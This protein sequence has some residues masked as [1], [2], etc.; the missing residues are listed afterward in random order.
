M[1][2]FLSRQSDGV[3]MAKI[4]RFVKEQNQ[5]KFFLY[6]THVEFFYVKLTLPIGEQKGCHR[7]TPASTAT[8]SAAA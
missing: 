2:A 3:Q 5:Q 4:Q 7:L 8:H 6:C 1:D